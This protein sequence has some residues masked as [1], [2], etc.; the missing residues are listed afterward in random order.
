[1]IGCSRLRPNAQVPAGPLKRFESAALCEPSV[2]GQRN[3]REE[4]RLGRLQARIRAD[5][6]VF[7]LAHVRPPLEQRGRQADRH[8]RRHRKEIHLRCRFAHDGRGVFP[9]QD[10]QLVLG[11][12]D[13]ARQFGKRRARRGEARL[14]AIHVE[15]RHHAALELRP[16]QFEKLLA[17]RHRALRDEK[18]LIERA[19]R[20]IAG[21]HAGDDRRPASRRAQ[22]R[23]RRKSARA[24]AVRLAMRFHRSISY[25]TSISAL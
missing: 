13:Q 24:A 23:T 22:I 25:D 15:P 2:A 1:M 19:Q 12:C 16:R 10:L 21:R 5:Q 7:R 20:E 17:R 18:L 4:R 9:E 11:L 3:G 6:D 8:L 14:G